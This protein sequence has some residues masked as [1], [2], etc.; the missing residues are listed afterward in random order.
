MMGALFFFW[1]SP[2]E[3]PGIFKPKEWLSQT[4]IWM[5]DEEET[6]QETLVGLNRCAF[7][8]RERERERQEAVS[9][10]GGDDVTDGK[11]SQSAP[12][13]TSCVA[14][15]NVCQRFSI[16]GPHVHLYTCRQQLFIFYSSSSIYVL[17]EAKAFTSPNLEL[18]LQRAGW[19]FAGTRSALFKEG[20]ELLGQFV[21]FFLFLFARALLFFLFD[22]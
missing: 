5:N 10:R 12:L 3:T 18:W 7:T 15:S 8:G 21:L 20:R 13:C 1:A 22:V 16:N 9:Q 14:A 2:A 17:V 6:Q 4:R 19:N 11:Q